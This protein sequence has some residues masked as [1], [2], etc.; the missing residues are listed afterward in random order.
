M[1]FTP[2]PQDIQ[3]IEQYR[4]TLEQVYQSEPQKIKQL[5]EQLR[6]LRQKHQKT[7]TKNDRY[8]EQIHYLLCQLDKTTCPLVREQQ[9]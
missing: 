7:F 4:T 6:P 1:A 9:L 2:T 8:L 3:A 5:G